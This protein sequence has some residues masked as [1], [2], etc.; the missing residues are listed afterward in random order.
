MSDQVNQVPVSQSQPTGFTFSKSIVLNMS[1]HPNE[2]Q[3]GYITVTIS[4][5]VEMSDRTSGDEFQRARITVSRSI[6]VT[7]TDQG[8]GPPENQSQQSPPGVHV[9]QEL[10]GCYELNNVSSNQQRL[11]LMN[12]GATPF[13]NG[14]SGRPQPLQPF[15][16]L[17]ICELILWLC[18]AIFVLLLLGE[19]VLHLFEWYT[20][21]V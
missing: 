6:V 5:M 12:R 4:A 11:G 21:K 3:Q 9:Y 13:G 20:S 1:D 10:L 14:L 17:T 2:S 7:I 8:D 18:C 15:T 16:I 19:L